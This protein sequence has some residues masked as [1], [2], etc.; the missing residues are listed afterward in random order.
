MNNFLN[1]EKNHPERRTFTDG[2]SFVL[3][4]IGTNFIVLVGCLIHRRTFFLQKKNTTN[5]GVCYV[6]AEKE[7]E[8]TN[9]EKKVFLML[10]YRCCRP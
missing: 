10:K 8:K 7:K 5:D 2:Y 3:R 4:N 6:A 9:G 1:E